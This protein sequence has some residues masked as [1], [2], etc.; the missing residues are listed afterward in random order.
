M[1]LGIALV[2]L[3][4]IFGLSQMMGGS[5]TVAGEE[6]EQQVG[7]VVNSTNMTTTESGLM[8]EDVVVGTGEVAQVGM[9]V[10]AHYTG[11]FT[12]G[13]V[14]DSSVPRNQ[15][16]EF[17]LGTGQVIK[18]WDEGIEGMKVG[19]KRKLVVPPKLGYGESGIGPIPP[20]ATLHFEVEL[21]AVRKQ[22]Q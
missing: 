18:G 3:G 2:V 8:Y 7:A 21:L 10:S 15:P 17:T 6:S 1:G 5:A 13:S 4:A 16:F 20:N 11:T 9:V 22:N 14:F 19:G 12:D